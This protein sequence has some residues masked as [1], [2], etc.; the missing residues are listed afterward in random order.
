M[1]K[2]IYVGFAILD[3]GNLHIYETYYDK[4]QPYFGLENLQLH[5]FDTDGTMLSRKTQKIS[6]I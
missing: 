5:Y 2:A 3:L 4:L 6:K 1:G